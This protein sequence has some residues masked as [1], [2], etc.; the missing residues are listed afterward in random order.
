MQKVNQYW[1]YT[2]EAEVSY[3]DEQVVQE[4]VHSITDTANDEVR[5]N[6]VLNMYNM[7]PLK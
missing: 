3:N 5:H 2:R 6:D 1:L 7:M 4:G